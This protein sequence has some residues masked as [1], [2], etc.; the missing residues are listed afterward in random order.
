MR[1]NVKQ[2]KSSENASNVEIAS[3]LLERQLY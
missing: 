1:A 3:V 2:N